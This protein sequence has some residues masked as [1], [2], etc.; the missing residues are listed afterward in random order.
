MRVAGFDGYFKELKN[1]RA[2]ELKNTI[3]KAIARYNKYRSPE[4][5]AKLLSNKR[6]F[7]D[8]SFTGPFCRTCGFHDYFDD[9][10]VVLED[11]GVLSEITKIREIP[12]G[13][14][15]RFKVSSYL[16]PVS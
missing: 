8:V 5:I 13:A 9:L 14:I 12:E 1:S 15:V 2:E 7:F 16:Y 6:D 11:L 10:K 3:K 4:V